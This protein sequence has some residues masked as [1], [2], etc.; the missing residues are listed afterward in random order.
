MT[1]YKCSTGKI[2]LKLCLDRYEEGSMSTYIVY[3]YVKVI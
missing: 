1:G 2:W 3:I